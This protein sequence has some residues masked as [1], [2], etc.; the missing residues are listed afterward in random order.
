MES[1]TKKARANQAGLAEKEESKIVL[2]STELNALIASAVQTALANANVVQ[3]AQ[4]KSD[5]M[6]DRDTA[7]RIRL[8]QDFN[9][10]LLDNDRLG[11]I[12][13]QEE[14]VMYSIPR[15]QHF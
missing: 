13:S 12:I 5:V 7:P 14:T 3:Q 6:V 4:P 10:R 11:V 8:E 9:K 1:T 2:T 15:I